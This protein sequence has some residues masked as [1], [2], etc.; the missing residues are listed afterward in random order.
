MVQRRPTRFYPH[1]HE[2]AARDAAG[3]ATQPGV[4]EARAHALRFH[5]AVAI[6][7]TAVVVGVVLAGHH[8]EPASAAGALRPPAVDVADW[9]PEGLQPIAGGCFAPALATARASGL[10]VYLHGRYGPEGANEERERQTRVA[11]T[12]SA[13]GY[14]VL[15]LRGAQGQCTDPQLATWWCWPSNER[16]L[17]AGPAFV[18][19]FEAALAEAERRAGKGRRVLLGFSNGGYFA[20]MIASRALVPFDAVVV[21]HAGPVAPMHPAGATP[22][23]SP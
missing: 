7:V 3:R 19:R 22:P 12:G 6:G 16:S 10:L 18:A 5:A 2:E 20:S 8:R 1:R 13:R 21:A 4:S 23:S 14:A 15:A 17:A 9:C 11:R